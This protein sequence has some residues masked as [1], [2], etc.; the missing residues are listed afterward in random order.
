MFLMFAE[1]LKKQNSF[2]VGITGFATLLPEFI[3][4]MGNQPKYNGSY[5]VNGS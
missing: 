1:R 3:E 5:K 4:I 2:S